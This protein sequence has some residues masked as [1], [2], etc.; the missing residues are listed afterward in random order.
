MTQSADTNIF[1]IGCTDVTVAVR[2]V[3]NALASV[4]STW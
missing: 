3:S 1:N 2:N 4:L